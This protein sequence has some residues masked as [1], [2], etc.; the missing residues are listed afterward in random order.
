M[1]MQATRLSFVTLLMLLLTAC[2]T[3]EIKVSRVATKSAVEL[4]SPTA[5]TKALGLAP[6]TVRVHEP[7]LFSGD[8]RPLIEYTAFRSEDVLNLMLG[9]D[10]AKSKDEIE[11][12]ALDGYFVRIP[13]AKLKR[14]QAYFAFARSDGSAFTVDNLAQQE[15]NLALGPYY[16][17][18][19]NTSSHELMREGATDWPYQI[20][21]VA[22]RP[23]ATES[24][25]PEGMSP[26]YQR[27]AQ[28]AQQYCLTCHQVNGYGGDKMPINLA[29][30]VKGLSE[31]TFLAW[32]LEPQTVNTYTT[33][34]ALAP[35]L[36][37]AEREGIA[38]DLYNYFLQLPIQH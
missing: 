33:M 31:S 24:L 23:P 8:D 27:H 35:L 13:V 12:R 5:L 9:K 25:M 3:E 17:I 29:E 4:P 11:L 36:P 18:W 7:H 38:G 20:N 26:R 28:L 22:L 34:P 2:L 15:K 32:V 30:Q 16:L 19:D 6:R 14:Y 21:T 1:M 10:W 37:Q